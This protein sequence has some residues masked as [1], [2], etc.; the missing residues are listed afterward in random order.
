MA[1]ERDRETLSR[2]HAAQDPDD[3]LSKIANRTRSIDGLPVRVQTL[4][5][6]ATV[7][8]D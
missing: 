1:F 3:R 6:A 8:A 4:M 2:Y 7:G 5:P